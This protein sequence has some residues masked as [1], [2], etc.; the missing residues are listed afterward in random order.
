[1]VSGTVGT[2]AFMAPETLDTVP[3]SEGLIAFNG[4]ALDIWALGVSLYCFVFG[5]VPFYDHAIIRL[6]E[7]IL[8]KELK[9]E[10]MA[11]KFQVSPECTNLICLMLNRTPGERIGIKEI[12]EHAWLK[13]TF[14]RNTETNIETISEEEDNVSDGSAHSDKSQTVRESASLA[15]NPQDPSPK[16]TTQA[17]SKRSLLKSADLFDIWR[18]E[19]PLDLLP[20][21]LIS[22]K[23]NVKEEIHITENDVNTAIDVLPSCMLTTLVKVKGMLKRKTFNTKKVNNPNLNLFNSNNKS[24]NQSIRVRLEEKYRVTTR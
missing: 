8:N 11:E 21:E 4:P 6:H 23:E 18:D 14:V 24:K 16:K 15:Y 12:R 7:K 20:L 17:T 19:D 5:E 2:P 22:I 13:L 1:M 3:N 9:L 10:T